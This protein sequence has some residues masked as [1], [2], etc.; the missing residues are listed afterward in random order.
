LIN[1]F[2]ERPV[3]ASVIAIVIVIA[4]AI[5]IP[6]LPVAQFPEITPPTVQVT[7]SYTGANAEV[8]EETVTTPLEESINGVEGMIYMDSVS[9]DDGTMTITVTFDV[10]YDL[11][12]AEVDT[13]IRVQ[14][15]LPQLP[16]EVYREGVL[17]RKVSTD[18]VIAVNLISPDGKYDDLFLSNYA[19]I[20]ITEVLKRIP[21]VGQVIIYGEREYSMR[22]WLDPDKLASLGL[23]ASDVANAVR[24]QN[25]QV[26]AGAIGQPPAPR[27]QQF[28]YTITTLG[29]LDEVS[30]FEDII[31][32]TQS[33][34]S[35]VR[36][37]DVARVELGAQDYSSYVHIDGR[38]TA[39]IGVL[40]FP[41][42]NDLEVAKQV[43]AEMERLSKRF[44]EGLEYEIIYDTTL[45]V[46]ESIKEVIKTLFEAILLVFFVVYIF[47]Q[48]WRATLIPAI[49]IP[50]CL[51]GT[52]ALINALGF[53]INLLTLFGLVLATGLVVDDAIVVVE[54]VARQMEE[55]W[56]KPL[57][58]A[59]EA[60]REVTGPIIATSLV[61]M[62]VFIPV[63]FIPGITGQFYR[64][65]ALTIACSVGISALNALTLSPA[66]CAVFLKPE[67]G[68]Q[69]LLFTKFNQG[70][71]RL[72]GLYEDVIKD[73]TKRWRI[74]LVIFIVLLGVTYLLFR[75]VPTGF[76]PDEDQGYFVVNI[77]TPDGSSLERTTKV[78]SQVEKILLSTP[79]MANVLTFGGY[80]FVTSASDPNTASMFPILEPWSKRKSKDT[81]IDAILGSVREKFAG[82]SGAEVT[83]FNPPAIQGLGFAG[84][85]QFELQDIGS[86]GFKTLQDVM[87]EMINKGNERPDLTSLFSSFTANTPKLYIDLDRT[88]A[89]LLDISITDVFDTLQ[90]YLGA[91][92]VNN[93][94]KYGRVYWVFLQADEDARSSPDDITRLYVRA[95]GDE[96]VPLSTLVDVSSVVGPQTITHYNLYRS[97]EIDGQASRGYSSGQVIKAMEEL[98]AEILPDGMGYEWTGIA[99][100]EI[101][102]GNLAPLIFVLS[103]VFVFLFLAALYESWVMPFMII[104]AVPLA[105][106]GALGAQWLRGLDNDVYCQIGLVMLIGL[107]SKNSILIVEFAK[108]RREEGAS[109]IDAALEA[110]RIRLRPILMTAFAFILGVLP[111]VIASG[112][113][114][115]SRHSLGTAVF[116]GMIV[117]TLL[118]LLVVPVFYVLIERLK[119]KRVRAKIKENGTSETVEKKTTDE[120]PSS[121]LA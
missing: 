40:T 90:T 13:Q 11:D 48:G 104:L 93:F 89:K 2:I 96:M 18:F 107:A 74:V 113:G 85:F 82:V 114:E 94:N 45:F 105:L 28:Q 61:L 103:L 121:P 46:K 10:G 31:V 118:S 95:S 99:Y 53:S 67:T 56:T 5:S 62:A 76:I 88:K 35:V 57:D 64:Q 69:G 59:R 42:A 100:Q 75:K 19:E 37:K 63:A 50:V 109:I 60:M 30:E 27:G 92:Y 110:A 44:P 6:T 4:G 38:A 23:T 91:L 106:L 71:N 112:A 21:G 119:E 52:F 14:N 102:A 86:V 39:N 9:N 98:A 78:V 58:A 47:L 79:G 84:G 87:N 116:G 97:A 29:L 83:A 101:K 32:R 120:P 80:S 43:R 55:K 65:F 25:Q 68:R 24:E 49:T 1:F 108:R 66:L 17:V 41:G 33:D 16:D 34:G 20:N 81:Q 111:L 7:A 117:A 8:V 70:F 72:K 54:N 115:N 12:I 36:I 51:I 77:Q 73:F 3:F 26:A 22:V 15:A